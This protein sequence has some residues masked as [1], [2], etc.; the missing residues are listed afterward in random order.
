MP[1][2]LVWFLVAF[3]FGYF[4]AR[5]ALS[6]AMGGYV[7]YK[8]RQAWEHPPLPPG[9]TLWGPFDLDGTWQK[10]GIVAYEESGNHSVAVVQVGKDQEA[11]VCDG[12]LVG[13]VA[14]GKPA[15]ELPN[16]PGWGTDEQGRLWVRSVN[17]WYDGKLHLGATKLKGDA[18]VRTGRKTVIARAGHVLYWFARD[19]ENPYEPT[20]PY[21]AYDDEVF[22]PFSR[23]QIGGLDRDGKPS[24]AGCDAEGTWQVYVRDRLL[25][26][27]ADVGGVDCSAWGSPRVAFTYREKPD[28]P[29]YLWDNG[30]RL[31]PFP[32]LGDAWVSPDGKRF[33]VVLGED[34]PYYQKVGKVEANGTV[35]PKEGYRL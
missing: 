25:G 23:T 19:Y 22:G 13:P 21:L 15:L 2:W 17:L 35:A 3:V 26:P 11:W 8:Q 9:G 10:S 5:W 6:F 18:E 12:K 7:D 24:F 31:G 4:P 14:G 30:K 33:A 32:S 27:Y 28:G 34:T 1:R 16:L 20:D 29:V